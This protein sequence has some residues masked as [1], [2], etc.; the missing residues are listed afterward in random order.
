[1]N[2]ATDT[3]DKQAPDGRQGPQ[4]NEQ[5]PDQL[6]RKGKHSPV[7]WLIFAAL[8][9][10]A[11]AAVFFFGWLPRHKQKQEI[12]REAQQEKTALPR[13][14][15]VKIKRASPQSE[16]RVPGTT[17]AYTEANIYARASGYLT[18]RLV[19]IGDHVHA[20]QLM[21]IIDAPDLDKQVS[22]AR[23]ALRQSESN[24]AQLQA[25]LRLASLTWDRYK[26]LVAKGVFSRQDGD[27]QEAN[28]R[29]AEAN[30]LAAQNA[31][32]ANRDNLERLIVL[33]QYERVTAPFDG[34][35]TARNVDLG[36]LITAQGTGVS[37]SSSTTLPGTTQSA[38]VGNNAGT[39]GNV[40]SQTS[41]S[42]GGSQGGALFTVAELSRLRILVSVPEAYTS[43]VQSGQQATVLFQEVPNESFTGRVSRTSAAIDQNT[44][45]LLV[46]VQVRNSK[47]R[48]LPGMY[49]Q[50]SLVQT[51][52][53]PPILI[54]GQAIV[55]RNGKT[56]VA[57]VEDE[58]VHLRPITIGRDYGDQTEITQGLKPGD[59]VALDVS[60][61]VHDGAKIEP[62]F[63]GENNGQ[64][65]GQSDQRSNTEGQYG[66]QNLSNQGAKKGAPGGGNQGGDS[67][68]GSSG[69]SGSGSQSK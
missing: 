18:K 62:H 13:V 12:E 69:G 68:G 8:I 2:M 41:P 3:Q 65:V 66:N 52:T 22:Q 59:V 47:N 25:Q 4:P 56:V 21:A 58:Y 20:G 26:V 30:V 35:V 7:Y 33:Q 44:R 49:A 64:K 1:M 23:S 67:K 28:F 36:T 19:D 27:T 55:V 46:E 57:L 38:A 31:V 50:V 24:V 43:L 37:S 53:I 40:S 17:Q 42:T 60:D 15:V 9:L 51:Q 29:V 48:L 32:Q 5:A 39:S 11:A 6:N 16:L 61:A 54:P 34:V 10:A 45:T 63:A 14:Q